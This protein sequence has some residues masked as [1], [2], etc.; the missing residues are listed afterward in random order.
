[1][2]VNVQKE[3]KNYK[4][5]LWKTQNKLQKQKSTSGKA[6]METYRWTT[7]EPTMTARSTAGVKTD[8]DKQTQ[9]RRRYT[10]FQI[11]HFPQYPPVQETSVQ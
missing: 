4:S 7:D 2:K 8:T 5:N 10:V 6:H 1:M 3:I 9:T 11:A